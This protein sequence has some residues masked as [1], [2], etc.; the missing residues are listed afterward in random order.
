MKSEKIIVSIRD[1]T[2]G[3]VYNRSADMFA[4]DDTLAI[5]VE[6]RERGE[7]SIFKRERLIKSISDGNGLTS[8]IRC[9][10]DNGIIEIK[11]GLKS[12]M[13]ICDYVLGVF[14][15]DWVYFSN[16]GYVEQ[17][18]FLDQEVELMVYDRGKLKTITGERN[19]QEK[20]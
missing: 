9:I 12:M 17:E 20:K 19:E 10:K 18:S 1:L 15:I 14:S 5:R 6:D 13:T 11:R 2:K 16:L 4:L 7:H 8:N 3:M